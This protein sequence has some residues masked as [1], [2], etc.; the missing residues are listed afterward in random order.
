MEVPRLGLRCGHLIDAP[1]GA[2][3]AFDVSGGAGLGEVQQRG[4]VLGSGDAGQRPDLG[5]GNRP[6]LHRG[7]HARE[8][9]Q[10]VGDADLLAGGAE[11]DAR[12]PVQPVRTR[13]EAI[14]PARALVEL[15]QQ[16]EQLVGGGMQARGQGGDLLAEG[17]GRELGQYVL[18][19]TGGW[20]ESGETRD[21]VAIPHPRIAV[22][23]ASDWPQSDELGAIHRSAV[24]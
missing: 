2:D 4:L 20:I 24:G 6:A 15:A 11:G 14:V 12:A 23:A 3:Q 13:G 18:R 8:R 21:A 10:R 17:I 9:R 22:F 7:A 5:V 19:A 1:P 16:H